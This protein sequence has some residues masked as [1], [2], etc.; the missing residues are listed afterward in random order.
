MI[1]FNMKVVGIDI[2]STKTMV[3]ADDAEIILTSTG[4]IS[5]PTLMCFFG[6]TRLL[7]EEA[8]PQILN[9]NTIPY[10]NILQ[11]PYESVIQRQ[12]FRYFNYS[13]KVYSHLLRR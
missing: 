10:L 2:G 9:E 1:Y 3:V 6:R 11:E 12:Y 5:T 13:L 7:G 8:L 4:S